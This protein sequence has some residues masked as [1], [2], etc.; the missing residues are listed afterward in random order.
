MIMTFS[1]ERSRGKHKY[2]Q[3]ERL[4]FGRR[5]RIEHPTPPLKA[6]DP[7]LDKIRKWMVEGLLEAI[8]D[9]NTSQIR[10]QATHGEFRSQ[11]G[12]SYRYVFNL[13]ASCKLE[14]GTPIKVQIASHDPTSMINGTVVETDGMSIHIATESPLPPHI[15]Q[16]VTFYAENNWLLKQALDIVVALQE[17]PAQLGAKTFGV[18]KSVDGRIGKD[19]IQIPRGS[20]TLDEDQL[21]ALW[22]GLFCE[23]LRLIGPPGSGK[24]RVL[25]V[26]AWYYLSQGM[27]VLLLSQTN[28]AVDNAIMSLRKLCEETGD[29]DWISRHRIVRIGN[30]KDLDEEVYQDIL[31][32]SIVDQ[33]LGEMAIRRDA[34]K[35]EESMLI[36]EKTEMEQMLFQKRQQWMPHRHQVIRSLEDVEKK[37]KAVYDRLNE[38]REAI[39]QEIQEQQQK[40]RDAQVNLKWFKEEE[41]EFIKQRFTVEQRRKKDCEEQIKVQA[42]IEKVEAM[43]SFLR[44]FYIRSNTY[45]LNEEKQ[46]LNRLNGDII[47]VNQKILYIDETLAMIRCQKVEPQSIIESAKKRERELDILLTGH[48][49]SSFHHV[50]TQLEQERDQLTT[51]LQ[52]GDE[53]V[54]A[55]EQHIE[56]IRHRRDEIKGQLEEIEREARPVK[57]QVVARADLI[58]ATLTS[59]YTSPY[60]KE[61][62]VDC[63]IID[64]TSMA[65]LFAVLVAAAHATKHANFIGDP[66]QAA[67][68]AGLHHEQRYPKARK[69]LGTDLFSYLNI[70]VEQAKKGEKQAVFLSQQSRMDEAIAQPVSKYIYHGQLKNRDRP[71]Y[72]RPV[73]NP[74]PETA[75]LAVDTGDAPAGE[76]CTER[77]ANEKS[78]FNDYHTKCVV[79]LVRMLTTSGTLAFEPYQPQIGIVTPYAPQF[80][81][82]EQALKEQGL[83][84][85]ARVGTIFAFQ[86]RE[87]EIVIV[88][89]V[90]SP[91]TLIPRFTSDI[92]GRNGIATPATRLIN[93]AHSRARSKLI[94]VTNVAYHR[95]ET[96]GKNHVLL[97]F[98]NDAVASGHL[99]SQ[100]LFL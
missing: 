77:P 98:I 12:E 83:N 9:A 94:Y 47:K 53:E 97:N 59:V 68:I 84:S 50:R 4:H 93:V 99:A 54:S 1:S 24:T 76:C 91:G 60:L 51:D 70:T 21:Q 86:G 15:L 69:W 14:N 89:L 27:T 96:G 78:K 85:Y 42:E 52:G 81:K 22:R 82:I 80:R 31:H 10:Y 29:T 64:E 20:F 19:T 62:Y 45:D 8:D 28:V 3:E 16:L 63:V 23:I 90:E 48:P 5:E 38:E 55:I 87:F 95:Q 25:A 67:P 46:R 71:G 100:D 79:Q 61:R 13:K 2:K 66:L 56:R 72:V 36:S 57:E 7:S 43:N 35:N 65:S 73:F 40:W 11:R 49:I 41:K 26:L 18:I 44:F 92:W 74:L 34:L 30:A 6:L 75:W 17:T 33:E 88:D 32:T 58:A 39:E 37:L